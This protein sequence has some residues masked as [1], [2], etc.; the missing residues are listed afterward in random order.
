MRKS[1]A[2]LEDAVARVAGWTL[3]A[4]FGA[5]VV[6]GGLQVFNRFVLNIS[7]SWSEEFQRFGQAWLVFLG[8]ALAYSRGLH[9]GTK[10]FLAFF[11]QR[12]QRGVAFAIHAVWLAVGI[13]FIVSGWRIM[14]VGANQLSAGM[15]ISMGYVYA[16]IVISGVYIVLLALSRLIRLSLDTTGASDEVQPW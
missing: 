9:I 1:V 6:V 4:I 5:I 14:V 16:V 7:L 2:R 15:E 3:A 11:P 10:F 8:V 12:A 13:V